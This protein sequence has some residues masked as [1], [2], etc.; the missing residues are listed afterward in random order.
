MVS[1]TSRASFSALA[2]E[3]DGETARAF[4]REWPGPVWISANLSGCDPKVVVSRIPD[5]TSDGY[6]YER[7]IVNASVECKVEIR[8]LEPD[9]PGKPETLTFTGSAR[10]QQSSTGG[11]A[12]EPMQEAARAAATKAAKKLA[13]K[14]R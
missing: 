8:R 13:P 1:R 14:K 11:L 12:D 4:R 9:R 7:V 10:M 6:R 3:P 5:Q 2:S